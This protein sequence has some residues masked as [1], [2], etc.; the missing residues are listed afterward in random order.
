MAQCIRRWQ[1][2]RSAQHTTLKQE[3]RKAGT[4]SSPCLTRHVEACAVEVLQHVQA[5]LARGRVHRHLPGLAALLRGGQGHA[6]ARGEAV[7]G[8]GSTQASALLC[9]NAQSLAQSCWRTPEGW[10]LPSAGQC[11]P[12]RC[13]RRG[14]RRSGAPRRRRAAPP[15]RAQTARRAA[16]RGRGRHGG[17][18]SAGEG[19]RAHPGLQQGGRVS[20][21]GWG[22]CRVCR[23]CLPPRAEPRSCSPFPN[24]I[25][26]RC[27][28][29]RHL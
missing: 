20:E 14:W 18:C 7:A 28:K 22:R 27:Q 21:G 11:Q 10:S 9:P 4:C 23:V 26:H 12:S 2:H 29:S 17:R 19:T 3:S 8:P 25:L 24:H 5:A 15:E 16:R 1:G 6:G 13:C